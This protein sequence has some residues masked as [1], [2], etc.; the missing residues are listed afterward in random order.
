MN[1][2]LAA[3]QVAL[4]PETYICV[5]LKGGDMA[6]EKTLTVGSYY[7]VLLNLARR[8]PEWQPARFTGISADSVGATWDYI[9]FL[10]ADGH[11]F[12][13]VIEVGPE[14]KREGLESQ[15]GTGSGMMAVS[16]AMRTD[17]EAAP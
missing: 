13:N 12:V 2:V 16:E 6:E 17:D 5:L 1:I 7:W 14:I 9:G 11:H 3:H 10:S 15:Y 4:L 8:A